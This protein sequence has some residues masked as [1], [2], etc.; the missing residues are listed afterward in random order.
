EI[1]RL[2]KRTF[3]L[4]G[5]TLYGFLIY[6]LVLIGLIILDVF[7]KSFLAYALLLLF[8]PLFAWVTILAVVGVYMERRYLRPAR[9]AWQVLRPDALL[10]DRGVRILRHPPDNEETRLARSCAPALRG[11]VGPHPFR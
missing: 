1:Y 9:K 2:M 7:G 8:G 5:P 4:L 6:L 10:E 11:H 3:W